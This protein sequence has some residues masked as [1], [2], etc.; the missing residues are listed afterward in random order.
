MKCE[1]SFAIL[2]SILIKIRGLMSFDVRARPATIALVIQAAAMLAVL[3]SVLLL[4]FLSFLFF[5]LN[6]NF[7]IFSIVLMQ[8]LFAR[9]FL[10][11]TNMASWW[12]WIHLCFPLLGWLMFQLQLPSEV[13][14]VGFVLS[15]SFY[16]TT[17]RTQVPFFPSRP[18][19]WQQVVQAIPQN[20]ALRLIDIGSGLGDMSMYM[21]N[22]RSDSQIEGIEIAP[23]L[24]AISF[25][26][27]KLNRSSARFK[28]GNYNALNFAHY[29]VVF[30]YLSP[31]AMHDLWKKASKEMR[32]GSML[33][34]LEFDIPEIDAKPLVLSHHKH[35][36]IYIWV[37]S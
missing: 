19:V 1:K 24:W 33:M 12:R 6:L 2:A 16:W 34:S 25:V 27:A 30:A 32:P 36:D 14:F 28:L 5:N 18:V 10:S 11:F 9:F 3:A 17:F 13:Y 7:P 21:A 31:A 35:P 23:L 22:M 20:R 8:V 29:D 4:K 37:I 15:L 26:R